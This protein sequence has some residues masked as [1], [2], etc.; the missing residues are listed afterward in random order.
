MKAKTLIKQLL[1]CR[2]KVAGK[3]YGNHPSDKHWLDKNLTVEVRD[4]TGRP[5]QIK[6]VKVVN[7]GYF[8]G[9]TVIKIALSSKYNNI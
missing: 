4:T 7:H 8:S 3:E 6:S 2:R 1:E 5:R 9:G